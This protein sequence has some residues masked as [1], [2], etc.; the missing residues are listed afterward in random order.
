[1]TSLLDEVLEAHGGLQR[2][3][4]FSRVEAD[5]LT[6]GGMFP[7]KG[8]APDLTGRRMTVWLK[9]ERACRQVGE[10]ERVAAVN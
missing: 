5:A 1:M 4:Q 7:L 3:R 8:L 6:G 10:G 9:E 2:W